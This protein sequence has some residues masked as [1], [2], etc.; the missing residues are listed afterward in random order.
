M[1][2]LDYPLSCLYHLNCRVL[3]NVIDHSSWI[4]S[5]RGNHSRLWY[6]T[7]RQ[8]VPPRMLACAYAAKKEPDA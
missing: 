2:E 4:C 5:T 3:L 6:H 7:W 1:G 8:V